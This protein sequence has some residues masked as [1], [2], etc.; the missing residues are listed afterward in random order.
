MKFQ[1]HRTRDQLGRTTNFLEE[2]K[3]W[4]TKKG[5]EVI[6]DNIECARDHLV[7]FSELV[8]KYCEK[9]RVINRWTWCWE[10]TEENWSVAKEE[11]EYRYH[12]DCRA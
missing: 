2:H 8:M 3:W 7:H 11:R 12:K 10:L 1:A 5:F 9:K 6:R 4:M